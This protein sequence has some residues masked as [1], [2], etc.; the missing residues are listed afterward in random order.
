[1]SE[2]E[3]K[4]PVPAPTLPQPEGAP[5]IPD[6]TEAPTPA[7]AA[8]RL[9]SVQQPTEPIMPAPTEP[10]TPVQPVPVPDLMSEPA[11]EAPKVPWYKRFLGAKPDATPPAD[12]PEEIE[13]GVGLN[14]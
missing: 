14:E 6:T 13:K 9:P 8:D 12:S 3:P 1:M 11:P 2:I 10:M 4:T 5:V 7:G